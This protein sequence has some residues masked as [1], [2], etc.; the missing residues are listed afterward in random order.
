MPASTVTFT[1]VWAEASGEIGGSVVWDD[2]SDPQ[3]AGQVL[4]TLTRGNQTLD[5]VLTDADGSFAFRQLPPGAYNLVASYGEITQTKKILLTGSETAQCT[6]RLPR[7]KTNSVL[8]VLDGA[9]DVVVGNL[10]RLFDQ[11]P[12][13]VYTEADRTLVESGGKVE[14]CMTVQDSSPAPGSALEEA[15]QNAGSFREGLTL[16]LTL[17][18]SR[19][20]AS[21]A[22]LGGTEP[23]SESN[24][25]MEI[26]IP[27]DG[28]L[29]NCR[30]YRVLREHDGGIE[31]IPAAGNQWGEYFVLNEDRTVLTIFAK[32][33]S[34]YAVLYSNVQPDHGGDDSDS[35]DSS[36]SPAPAVTE[37]SEP[38]E[39]PPENTVT[40]APETA[41]EPDTSAVPESPEEPESPAPEQPAEPS[42]TT[43]IPA[44]KP[45]VLL[46]AVGAAVAV[47]LAALRHPNR[48]R[49]RLPAVLTAAGAVGVALLTTGWNGFVLASPWTLAVAGFALLTGWLTR[50]DGK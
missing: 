16:A 18:K 24:L 27:L 28:G 5:E 49:S 26:V 15:V 23:I 1:A 50:P 45:F 3:P 30:E 22:S 19:F 10:D 44:G 9:P 40:P 47:L 35:D 48:G 2:E 14:I 4:I 17:E 21:G 34:D 31:E 29:Q 13:Q 8:K 6:I 36:D 39:L 42:S 43:D 7:G 20:E 46:S 41:P 38:A 11:Q 12:D 32:R 33:F 25:L 37:P